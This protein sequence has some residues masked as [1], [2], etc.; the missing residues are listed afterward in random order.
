MTDIILIDIPNVILTAT[1]I[2]KDNKYYGII[3][4]DICSLIKQSSTTQNTI[5]LGYNITIKQIEIDSSTGK[6]FLKCQKN[7]IDDTIIG[8]TTYN[9]S[10]L[11][12][13]IIL[14]NDLSIAKILWIDGILSF[15]VLNNVVNFLIL[16][17]EYSMPSVI[18]NI[19]FNS[20]SISSKNNIYTYYIYSY[21][22][23]NGYGPLYMIIKGNNEISRLFNNVYINYN[24]L[25]ITGYSDSY[26]KLNIDNSSIAIY[27]GA[28][29]LSIKI[30]NEKIKYLDH[31]TIEGI[32]INKLIPVLGVIYYILCD[33]KENTISL[34]SSMNMIKLDGVYKY[35]KG[36]FKYDIS[37]KTLSLVCVTQSNNNADLYFNINNG[38]L[39]CSTQT[40]DNGQL[41]I[42]NELYKTNKLKQF[43]IKIKQNYSFND[44]LTW[45]KEL[46]AEPINNDLIKNIFSIDNKI[47]I[48]GIA[49]DK[50]I[51]LDNISYTSNNN[52]STSNKI[53]S[54]EFTT[55]NEQFTNLTSESEFTPSE[56]LDLILITTKTQD[57]PPETPTNTENKKNIIIIL[58]TV[59]GVLLLIIILVLLY[60]FKYRKNKI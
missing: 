10:S 56:I 32:Y 50:S 22:V 46:K 19:K 60:F 47:I 34:R 7:T 16:L 33:V 43:I 12:P 18:D 55:N 13:F 26:I 17:D 27:R 44:K 37:L 24:S 31:E 48:I 54:L 36:I 9:S 2:D 58:S 14:N 5:V 25:L 59:F 49:N 53:Y 1:Q 4:N 23:S 40:D 52:T 15:I 21:N 6:I 35:R 30:E 20:P 39:Y 41:I 3:N 45:V 51:S 28:F 38:D 11:N 29:I 8:G 57:T 42:N